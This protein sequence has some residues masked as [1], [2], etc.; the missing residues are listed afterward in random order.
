MPPQIAEMWMDE[1][2]DFLTRYA[3]LILALITGVYAYLT[4]RM[5]REMRIAREGQIDANVVASP[6]PMGPLYVQVVMQNA[7]PGPAFDVE[8]S[9]S[10]EPPLDTPAKT[11]R[12]PVLM[13]NQKEKFLP[14]TREIQALRDLA[15]SHDYLVV[16][17]RWNNLF[18]KEHSTSN[19][20][21]LASLVEGWYEAGHL[22]PP[23]DFES[24]MDDISKTLKKLR[25]DV[26]K[27]ARSL[28]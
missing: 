18:G 25:G 28:G 14:P 10:L 12:H 26:D 3:S 19:R 6:V 11:W 8:I 1:F 22:I 27:I 5:A 20:H 24:Q 15:E 17:I 21:N 7:G 2:L 16:D 9:L 23:A 13:V 4:W